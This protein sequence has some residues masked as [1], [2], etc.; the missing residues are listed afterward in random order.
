MVSS[1]DTATEDDHEKHFSFLVRGLY[2]VFSHAV[3]VR[4]HMISLLRPGSPLVTLGLTI[5][6]YAHK[7]ST[8][9]CI[10]GGWNHAK[11]RRMRRM[12]HI[13]E[14]KMIAEAQIHSPAVQQ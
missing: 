12:R 8:I 6:E 13:F 14:M 10:K 1:A 11:F 3:S 4:V 5:D 7:G 9:L 2:N